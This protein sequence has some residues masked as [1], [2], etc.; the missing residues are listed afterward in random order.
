MLKPM[1]YFPQYILQ[2]DYEDH[3]IDATIS[4]TGSDIF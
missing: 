4:D 1:L 2:I 3:G